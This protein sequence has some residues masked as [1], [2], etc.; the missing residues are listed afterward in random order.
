MK[1]AFIVDDDP[2]YQKFIQI[3]LRKFGYQVHSFLD[4]E[5]CLLYMREKPDLIILGQSSDEKDSLHYLKEIKRI[6][7]NTPVLFLSNKPDTATSLE[8]LKLG[9][10][11]YVEKDS[12][13]YARLLATLEK[14]ERSNKIRKRFF[15]FQLFYWSLELALVIVA[16]FNLLAK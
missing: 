12:S 4:G 8:A 16:L 5:G 6:R 14:I 15:N 13:G 10:I 7:R 3:H 9:A 2:D 1:K 11:D